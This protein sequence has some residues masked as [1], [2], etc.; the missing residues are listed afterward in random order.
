MRGTE[1][2]KYI[3]VQL[4]H[5]SDIPL[6]VGLLT[7]GLEKLLSADPVLILLTV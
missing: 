2:I 4:S 3:K 7:E 1:V 5:F 6:E